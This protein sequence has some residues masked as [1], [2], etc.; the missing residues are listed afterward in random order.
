MRLGPRTIP[1][2]FKAREN[3]NVLFRKCIPNREDFKKF[4]YYLGRIDFNLRYSSSYQ[5]PALQ[6]N[7][8]QRK[9]S[10]SGNPFIT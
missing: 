4:V 6:L 8:F 3:I 10:Y 2:L 7:I 1:N 5:T 9:C